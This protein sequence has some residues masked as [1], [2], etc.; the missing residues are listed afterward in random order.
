MQLKYK[1]LIKNTLDR[2]RKQPNFIALAESS[3]FLFK[4]AQQIFKEFQAFEAT[5]EFYTHFL[6]E[7]QSHKGGFASFLE[8]VKSHQK[9]Y[10]L[11]T[12]IARLGIYVDEKALHKKVFSTDAP[13]RT[14]G[15]F[16]LWFPHWLSNC[17]QY[18]QEGEKVEGLFYS[19]A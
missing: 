7:Y 16:K 5:N 2:L 9:T 4:E 19:L 10:Q 13:K 8:H 18:K 12:L 14:L 15:T 3:Q 11:A 6:K 1:R 17:I